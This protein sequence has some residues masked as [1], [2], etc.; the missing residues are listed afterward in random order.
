MKAIQY[1][2]IL[3]LCAASL[4]SCDKFLTRDAE[5]Q[6]TDENWW[7]TKNQLNTVVNECYQAMNRGAI[8]TAE[9]IPWDGGTTGYGQAHLLNKIENEG[10][11]DNGI[12]C[13]NYIDNSAITSGTASGKH[14][15]ITNFW[16]GRYISIRLCCRFLEHYH[17]AIFDPDKQPYEGV[18]TIDRWAAEVRALRAYYHMDLYMNF[19][20]IPLVKTVISPQDQNLER[21]TREECISWIVSEFVEAAKNLPVKPQNLQDR[22]RWTKGAVY[23]YISYLYLFESD[24]E[25]AKLW[26]KKVI[27][28]GI[29]E[30]YESPNNP[31]NSYSEMFLHDAYD[32]YD[33]K[34]SILTRKDG[35]NEATVR[36]LCPGLKNGGTGVCPTASLVDE[37]ELSDGRTLSELTPA[38]AQAVRLAPK[39][40]GRDPRL[41]QTVLFPNETF[42][43][44]TNRVWNYDSAN[45]DYIGKR[46]STKTGYWV[47]KWVNEKDINGSSLYATHLPFMLMRYSVVLLN[48]AECIIELNQTSE[49]SVA[50]D[51]INRIRTRARHC[52]ASA[53]KYN[54]QDKLRELVRRERR[55]ELAFEGHRL[56]DIRRWKIGPETMNGTVY[57]APY[58]NERGVTELYVSEVRAFNP[59]RDY[60]WPIPSTEMSYNPKIKQN[61]GY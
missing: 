36:L 19:G 28:L 5:N 55:V 21:A 34:E 61:P 2:F 50:L 27:D 59:E 33:T 18:Q 14:T 31:A 48:Y 58:E 23:A 44:Y 25:N 41:A 39:S 4:S 6:T 29:Y 16:K 52:Q 26:A 49:F 45:L 53:A 22:W 3:G 30:L 56:F 43:G 13:A 9:S 54:T 47:K 35:C 37:Y 10:L 7:I 15:N 17:Q 1:I 11:S 42:L 24:W 57:G 60:L 12:T 46:N 40:V 20:P 8:M 38:A 51:Y 32:V